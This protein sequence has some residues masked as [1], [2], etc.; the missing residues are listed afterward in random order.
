MS[1][2]P[3]EQATG[4]EVM[5]VEAML[6][7][8][9]KLATKAEKPSLSALS[10]K[11]GMIS[12]NKTPVPGNQL[13]VII[14][15][16]TH[17]NA[18]YEGKYDPDNIQSPVCYAYSPDGENM[19]PHPKSSKPQHTDCATCPMNQWKSDPNGGKGK[20]CK[21]GR[22]MVVIPA[23]TKPEDVLNAEVAVASLPVTSV[24][25]FS[26]YVNKVATLFNRPLLGLITKIKTQPD[27]KTQ[28]K[29]MFENMNLLDK[30]MLIPLIKKAELAAPLLIR[31]YEPNVEAPAAAD[32]GKAKKF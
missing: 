1:T 18:Y 7:G 4:T 14:I 31:E 19:A 12:Y 22:S 13:D 28:F 8:M 27:M 24:A 6:A 3:E 20:A 11:S 2:K 16:S 15:A 17:T 23:D 5:D 21:N 25:N 9:A 30:D 10:F 26:N 32:N 29:V